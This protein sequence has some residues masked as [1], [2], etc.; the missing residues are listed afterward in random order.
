MKF[1]DKQEII[2]L[3]PSD[4][5]RPDIVSF[6]TDKDVKDFR[7]YKIT[8]NDS[9]QERVFQTYK[10]MHNNQTVDFV[11][12]RHSVWLKFNHFKAS[13]REALE[14]L[15]EL[16]DESDPDI[17]LP[18]IIHAFQAAERARHEYPD[19]DWLH[20]TALIHDL[21]KVMAFFDEPQW[22]VVGDTFPVGC[23]WS[24]HIVYRN[25]T[26]ESNRDGEN[27]R[28][29]TK[30][31]MYSEKCGIENLTFSWGHD[32]YLYSVLKHNK[33]TLPIEALQIIRFHS[34]YPWHTAGDYSYFETESDKNIKKWVNIFNHYDLYTKSSTVPDIDA[35]WPYY[36]SLIDKYCPAQL[37]F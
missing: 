5:Y 11:K 10:E 13:I 31:G 34:F 35:L 4:I 1:T 22:A 36:Q 23:L 15:N 6:V 12:G 8:E 18:N 32:E 19:V 29:N 25:E 20:L 37:E 9:L 17:D 7:N 3:D 21:G 14:K 28:Y 26:F 33:C 27:P 2:I 24:D 16:V 30:L